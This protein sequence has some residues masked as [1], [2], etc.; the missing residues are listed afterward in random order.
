MPAPKKAAV[1]KIKINFQ[2]PGELAEELL[3]PEGSTVANVVESL[4]L[5]GYTISLNGETVEAESTAILQKKDI[6]RVG[7]KTKNNR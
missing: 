7:V 2:R 3:I 6:L 4:N 1:K 5:D